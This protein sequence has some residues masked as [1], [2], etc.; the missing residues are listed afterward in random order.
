MKNFILSLSSVLAIA[1]CGQIVQA[2]PKQN[3][4]FIL[5]DDLGWSDTTLFGNTKFYQTPNIERLAKRGMT[6]SRAY[7]ASPLCSPTRSAIL[8]GMSPARTGI[9]TPNCH[10]P[11]VVLQSTVGKSAPPDQKSIQPQPTTRLKTEYRTL[12]ESFKDEGYATGHFGKWHLGPDPYSPLQQGF[13]VD[14]PHHSGPGPAGSFVAPWKFKDFDHDPLVP[15]QHL[16]DRMAKEATA[17]LEKHQNEPFFMNYWMFSVHAPFD[18]KKSLIEKHRARVDPADPQRSPTYAAMIESMD[19]AIGTLLDTLDRLKIADRTTII[20]T[21]DNGG[22]MYNEI[23]ETTPTSNLPLR[24]GKACMFEGGTR[25]PCVVVWPGVTTAGSYSDATI[26]SEDFYPTLLEGLAL[27][28][29][30]EQI[31]DGVSV[32]P[33]L[34]GQAFLRGAVFQYFPHS[35]GV[36]DWLPPAVSVHRDEWKLIRLFHGGENGAHRYLLFNLLEDIGE[37]NNLATNKPELVKELD[38]LIEEFLVRTN[39]VVPVPNPAF[40][41]S[42]YNPELEGKPAPRGNKKPKGSP[43]A[44]VKSSE[45]NSSPNWR[46]SKDVVFIKSDKHLMFQ[47]IGGDPWISTRAIPEASGPFTVILRLSSTGKGAAAIFFMSKNDKNFLKDRSI[48]FPIVHDGKLHQY[49]IEVP[50]NDLSAL[51]LD[52]G[53]A[54]GEFSCEQFDLRDS[55]GKSSSLL[56]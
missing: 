31:L 8:T 1:W 45:S 14:V 49:T 35:P 26:Q 12:A 13:D 11:Q 24:G 39:A 37:R 30:P 27:P 38:Q 9:T 55:T 15:D 54:P 22:N 41:P 33:A 50:A 47:S 42:R 19:D 4:I 36:P 25:V 21:S 32:L 7:S 10:L 40:N 18:A 5:A 23:D 20:F 28:K 17:F 34:K 48:D 6:F 46:S 51:R 56:R 16:E 53:V 43:A 44:P 29:Q 2:S 52:T 3:V